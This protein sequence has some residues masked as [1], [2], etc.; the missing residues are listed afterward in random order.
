MYEWEFGIKQICDYSFLLKESGE[1]S[2]HTATD[3]DLK[4]YCGD[5]F[6][7]GQNF[8]GQ[9]DAVWD[10]KA[11]IAVNVEERLK[12]RDILVSALKPNGRILMTTWVYEQKIH[13]KTPF[14]IPYTMIRDLFG[15]HCDTEKI[16]DIDMRGTDFCKRN[17]FPWATRPVLLLTKKH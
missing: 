1:F 3:R 10:C 11:I 7:I 5:I 12:Y 8:L 9:F 6:Q 14:S 15:S 4:I 13:L 16:E 17:G 2:V